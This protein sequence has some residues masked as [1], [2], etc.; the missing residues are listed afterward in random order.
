MFQNY[1]ITALRNFARH[2][3][4]SFI[5]IAGLTVGLACA[6]FI[7]LFVRDQLS[8][9]R[10]IPGSENLY[11]VEHTFALPGQAPMPGTQTPY[12]VPQAML[13]QIPEVKARTRF[14][15]NRATVFIGKKQF[16]ETIDSVDPNYFQVIRLPLAAGNP[17][18]V[19]AQPDSAVLSET[20]ARKYFGDAPALGKTITI[21]AEYCDLQGENCQ[22]RQYPMA[23]TGILRDLPHNTQIKADLLIPNTSK[24]DPTSL[25]AKVNWLH[26]EGWGYV[27]LQPGADPGAVT[28]KLAT[29]ID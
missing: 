22:A 28:A 13:D 24:A 26:I 23:V 15:R 16:A 9:D 10:W 17:A 8:Y 14:I 29:I 11:R 1:L 27:L 6:I 12:L 3:F 7:I 4:Y 25:D 5:N 18:S 20:L 21:S 19:F 2:K